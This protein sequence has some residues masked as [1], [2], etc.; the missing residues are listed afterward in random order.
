MM[1]NRADKLDSFIKDIID[2]SRNK[3]TE[4]SIEPVNFN[5]LL[6]EVMENFRFL[7]GAQKIRFEKKVHVNGSI[8]LD[9]SRV[10][11]VLNNLISNSIKYH[12]YYLEDPWI[13]VEVQSADGSVNITIADNGQ[14]ISGD[15]QL[16]IF[17]MFYRATDKSKGSGLGLYIVKEIVEKMDGIITVASTVDMGTSFQ[18][19]LPLVMNDKQ[20]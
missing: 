10:S 8:K 20:L 15:H 13:K 5:L 9:K 18:I 4:V 3:R 19:T 12:N 2:Y 16:K 6:D 14:G 11:V 7:E 17:D 1:A